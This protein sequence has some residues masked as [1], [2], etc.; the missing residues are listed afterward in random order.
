MKIRDPLFD[1]ATEA[2]SPEILAVND[3]IKRNAGYSLYDAQL[4]VAEAHKRCLER[5]KATLC[6]SECGSGKTKIGLTALHA[7]QQRNSTGAQVKH[8]NV[9]L[10]PSHM[11]KKWVREIEE[12]LPDT[13]ALIVTNINELNEVYE[14]SLRCMESTPQS[15]YMPC[16]PRTGGD[17]PDRLR[18]EVQSSG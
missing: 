13:F 4:A 5:T 15:V 14:A 2:L 12:S 18:L 3:H 9:V 8:F 1:P 16:L 10:C 6:I 7:H 11:T 17:G